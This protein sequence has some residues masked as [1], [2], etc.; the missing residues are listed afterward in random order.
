[1]NIVMIDSESSDNE[2]DKCVWDGVKVKGIDL[3]E[4]GK[5]NEEV[6]SR[7]GWVSRL[8]KARQHIKSI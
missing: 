1:M 5:V 2:D 6:Y 8:L 7:I 4:A 3:H